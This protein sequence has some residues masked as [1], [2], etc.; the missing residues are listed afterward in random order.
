MIEREPAVALA[1]INTPRCIYSAKCSARAVNV[2]CAV[3][4][5]YPA[6]PHLV[7]FVRKLYNLHGCSLKFLEL[8]L[9]YRFDSIIVSLGLTRHINGFARGDKSVKTDES[10][11]YGGSSL[12][13]HV[14][15]CATLRVRCLLSCVLAL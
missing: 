10:V 4:P 12:C 15:S 11:S 5:D 9:S 2:A 3:V 8:T 6:E 14:I 13:I 7:R 1:L